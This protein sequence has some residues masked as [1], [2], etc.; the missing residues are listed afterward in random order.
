MKRAI[1]TLV[2]LAA[3][4]LLVTQPIHLITSDLG[5]H[6]RTGEEVLA[7][8]WSVTRTNFYSYTHPEFPVVNHHWF[9]G[10]IF[11]VIHAIGG[12]PLLSI[13]S[14]L[15]LTISFFLF[16]RLGN[17]ALFP[18][19]LFLPLM[20]SRTEPRP[21]LFSYLFTGLFLTILRTRRHRWILPI[22]MVLWVNLHIYFPLG[23]LIILL[24]KPSS[25]LVI[26]SIAATFINP[27][28]WQGAI[29]PATLFTNY[30]YN[31][32]E[33]RPLWKTPLS[34]FPLI[35]YMWLALII[36][37][38]GLRNPL[39]VLGMISI[40]FSI[41]NAALFGF[42]GLATLPT[43]RKPVMIVCFVFLAIFVIK[44]HTFWS[45]RPFGIGS[46]RQ[47]LPI[48]IKGPI[49]NNYDIGGYLIFQRIPVFVDNRPEAY[50][51]SFFTDTYI[52]AQTGSAWDMM[53]KI[54]GFRTIVWAKTDVTAWGRL[55]LER[56][57]RDIN[58]RITYDSPSIIIL[59]K[60]L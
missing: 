17:G 40:L 7:G 60:T 27:N 22:L 53:Q 23:I 13:T 54:Y 29:A 21:E 37:V 3:F 47:S 41:R 33:N 43:L 34:M 57:Q 14:I 4:F 10:V 12:F 15:L 52:P 39:L 6:I 1:L 58:W 36:S 35:P 31:L 19:L 46:D 42:I 26:S 44:D 45:R 51:A 24:N 5:R 2:I 20:I 8:N 38:A 18:V 59:E 9:S 32:L 25:A 28:G 48:A 30:G 49:F 50:P 16:W 55:F 56:I 11:F